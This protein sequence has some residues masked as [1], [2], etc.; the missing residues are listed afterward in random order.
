MKHS[1][2]AIP[3]FAIVAF[4]VMVL[5]SAAEAQSPEE[6]ANKALVTHIVFD[7]FNQQSVDVLAE[8]FTD[9]IIVR[10]HAWKGGD[11]V[12]IEAT[13]EWLAGFYGVIPDVHIR[14]ED[15]VAEGD[16]VAVRYTLRGTFA[17]TGLPFDEVPELWLM[18]FVDGQVAEIWEHFDDLGFRQQVGILRGC[19]C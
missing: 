4:G 15:M 17:P 12:G 10:R 1:L 7:G 6:E 16:M 8:N 11:I 19:L 18:R 3:I 9:D 13:K 14:V 2:L 5:I